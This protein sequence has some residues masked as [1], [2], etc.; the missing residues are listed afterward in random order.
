VITTSIKGAIGLAGIDPRNAAELNLSG[1]SAHVY[2]DDP[3]GW[4]LP[5]K[6]TLD[7]FKYDNLGSPNDA[8]PRLRHPLSEARCCC[9]GPAA[10]DFPRAVPL[11]RVS[12]VQP[13][14]L[15]LPI[16]MESPHKSPHSRRMNARRFSTRD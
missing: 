2:L 12:K 5:G 13:T 1:S 4:P 10:R 11:S 6:L 7:G 15:N 8:D 14:R 9:H 16:L 3:A